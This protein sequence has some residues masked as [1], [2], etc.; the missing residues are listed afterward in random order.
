MSNRRGDAIYFLL[1]LSVCAMGYYAA[2]RS[3][4]PSEAGL[5]L[6]LP[7]FSLPPFVLEVPFDFPYPIV[8]F[9]SLAAPTLALSDNMESVL[10]EVRAALLESSKLVE[11]RPADQLVA[12]IE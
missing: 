4:D 10:G 8:E 12:N 3:P 2:S 11:V 9:K 7:D 1:F 6:E 5:P